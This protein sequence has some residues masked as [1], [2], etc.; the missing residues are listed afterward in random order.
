MVG[1][2]FQRER[3]L[4]RHKN[5]A[6]IFCRIGS[7]FPFGVSFL[8]TFLHEQKSMAVEAKSKD[9]IS[10]LSKAKKEAL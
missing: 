6:V 4:C 10:A 5:N 8:H 9:Y 3:E 7:P 1:L 2:G